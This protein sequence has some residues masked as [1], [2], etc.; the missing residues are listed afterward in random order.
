MPSLP[1]VGDARAIDTRFREKGR[2]MPDGL[3]Y[4]RSWIVNE[5]VRKLG[6]AML[7]GFPSCSGVRAR[8]PTCSPPEYG[9][10]MRPFALKNLQRVSQAKLGGDGSEKV[11][12][13]RVEAVALRPRDQDRGRPR[14][15]DLPR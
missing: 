15:G 8:D 12:G 14:G 13:A 3:E 11:L 4:V 2:M 5:L 10:Y 6:A 9:P 7:H 1:V